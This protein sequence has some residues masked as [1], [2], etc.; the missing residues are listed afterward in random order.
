MKNKKPDREIVVD[1][2]T[3]KKAKMEAAKRGISLKALI[4]ELINKKG[5]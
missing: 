5:K 4:R 3:H 1:Y 2:E